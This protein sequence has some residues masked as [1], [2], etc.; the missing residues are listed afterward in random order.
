MGVN[1]WE[2]SDPDLDPR[3]GRRGVSRLHPGPVLGESGSVSTVVGLRLTGCG[4]S[5]GL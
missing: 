3:L 1:V 5:T 4:Q 2:S